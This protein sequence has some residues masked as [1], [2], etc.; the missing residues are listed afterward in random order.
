MKQATRYTDETA[1]VRYV[2]K[3]KCKL[4][5]LSMALNMATVQYEDG[6][7]DTIAIGLLRRNP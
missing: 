2:R 1:P 7:F 5:R 6:T 4:L 3:R